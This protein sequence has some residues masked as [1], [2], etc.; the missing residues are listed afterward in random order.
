MPVR[1]ER[2]CEEW[3]KFRKRSLMK[4]RGHRDLMPISFKPPWPTYSQPDPQWWCGGGPPGLADHHLRGATIIKHL[5]IHNSHPCV[6]CQ[7]ASLSKES[8][9]S[10]Q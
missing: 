8:D 9:P 7:T 4:T 6:G 2:Q 1:S 3:P 5:Y 10:V